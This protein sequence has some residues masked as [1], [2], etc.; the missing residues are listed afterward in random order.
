[1]LFISVNKRNLIEMRNL[2]FFGIF[3]VRNF[4][5]VPNKDYL[6][7]NYDALSVNNDYQKRSLKITMNDDI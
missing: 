1:M 4:S 6:V 5:K 7:A 2:C 3:F